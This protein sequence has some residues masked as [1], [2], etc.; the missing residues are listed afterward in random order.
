[1]PDA[2]PHPGHL[3]RAVLGVSRAIRWTAR[4]HRVSMTIGIGL[5]LAGTATLLVRGRLPW[6]PVTVAV[7]F[8]APPMLAIAVHGRSRIVWLAPAALILTSW[9]AFFTYAWVQQ[10]LL[11]FAGHDESCSYVSSSTETEPEGRG[12]AHYWTVSCPDGMQRFSADNYLEANAAGLI[13][14]RTVAG[15]AMA[16]R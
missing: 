8:P 12:T 7:L 16:L 11:Q 15:G 1:M 4:H 14:V 3:A 10:V 9:C 5:I 6:W 2:P 13:S